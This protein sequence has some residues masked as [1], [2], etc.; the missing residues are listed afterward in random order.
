MGKNI[1]VIEIFTREKIVPVIKIDDLSVVQPLLEAMRDGGINVAEITYRTAFAKDAIALAVKSFP[2]M[3]VGAGTVINI[4]QAKEAIKLG[5][6]FVV[7][8]G[9]DKMTALYCKEKSVPYFGGC[10]TPTEIMTAVGLGFDVIKF[11]PSEAMG[12]LKT[13]KSLAAPFPG[14]KFMPTGGINI[15]NI[16]EYLSF[17]KVIACGGSWMVKSDLVK[18]RD[19][20]KIKD[21]CK[22]A[23]RE[24][25]S[26]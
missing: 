13:I 23:V 14:I 22:E 1:N 25:R 24:V 21:L 17:D 20:D 3:I 16:K 15:N 10:L 7:S 9:F 2:D 26:L 19:F 6:K 8:P 4:E 12:G 18:S 5:A 11:F